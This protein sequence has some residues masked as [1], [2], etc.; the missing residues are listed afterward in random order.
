MRYFFIINPVSGQGTAAKDLHSQ[1]Q[2]VSREM[3]I[4]A[5]VFETKGVRDAEVLASQIAAELQG[6]EAVVWA[7]GGDGTAGEVVNGIAGNPNI[8]L[9]IIPI[10]TGNDT[11]R[12][13]GVEK[14]AFLD[15]RAQLAGTPQQIDLMQYSGTVNGTPETR[16]C[17]NMFNNG[18][19]CNVVDA[20]AQM[21][22]LPLISGSVAY[23][24]GV[25]QMFVQKR[26]ISLRIYV[27]GSLVSSGPILLCSIANG[28]FCGGGICSSPQAKLNDGLMDLSI[29]GDTTRRRFLKLFPSY[30]KGEHLYRD[31]IQDILSVYA[32]KEIRLLPDGTDDFLFCADGETARTTGLTITI[33]PQALSFQVPARI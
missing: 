26:G 17:V 25:A 2:T 4:T 31:D 16:F 1:I 10:G 12:N 19:D 13:F 23:L 32:C 20:A 14:E 5:E 33:C 8:R 30:T 6:E 3:G 28:S 11:I 18:F 24:L 22:T 27:D 9:G 21:K 29:I 7:C 15:I